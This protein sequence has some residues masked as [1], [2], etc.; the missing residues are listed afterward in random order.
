VR[1]LGYL[2]SDAGMDSNGDTRANNGDALL[3]EGYAQ[4]IA[5]MKRCQTGD[6]F[7]ASTHRKSNYRRVWGRDGSILS[8]AA[9]MSGEPEL[10]DTARRTLRTL[11]EHQGPHGEI[12]SN[13]DSETGRISY[14]GTA[15]R[16][17]SDL[18]FVVACGELW[19]ATRDSTFLDEMMPVLQRVRF[20]LGC[21]EFNNRGLLYIPPT[22]DWADEYLHHGYVL[23]DQLLYLQAQRALLAMHQAR[24]GST[25]CGL[26]EKVSRLRNLIRTNYWIRDGE[27][28]PADVYH[29]VIYRKSLDA[30]ES[31]RC[32]HWLPFFS[33]HGYG[34]RFD[35]F[36]NMLATLVGVSDEKRDAAVECY[37]EQVLDSDCPLVPAFRPAIQP[38]DGDWAELKL[39]FSHTFKNRPF[40]YHNGGLW[41]MITGFY[42][43]RLCMIGRED[44]A[45]R[46]LA[47]LHRANRMPDDDGNSWSF[48]EY[49]H[50]QT[51]EPGGTRQLGWSAAGAVIGHH[52]LQGH[53]PFK[54]ACLSF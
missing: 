9:I 23:Y 7:L 19:H 12:P 20:L 18:W 25:D 37:V 30:Q 41:P 40:E 2:M 51:H 38:R 28:I 47:A 10:I 29:P 52:A 11:A 27:E 5:L 46:I 33:P 34:Y 53:R 44:R 48:P 35:G 22:G 26:L 3:A 42:V 54:I 4:A 31:R 36:A 8:V 6:G 32:R 49:L 17:D 21:W 15:G 50:G 39:T 1:R 43:A 24:Q 16:V 14:G 45:R 13:V